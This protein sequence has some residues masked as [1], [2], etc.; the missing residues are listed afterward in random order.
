MTAFRLMMSAAL[1]ASLTS[2]PAFAQS[3]PDGSAWRA[4]AEQLEGGVAVDM[5]LRDGQHF[6]ATFIA[7]RPD[8]VLV[9]RK[10]RVPVSVEQIN[11][12]SIA[13]LSRAQRSNLS[14]GKIAAI[15]LGSA[16]AAV[17]VLWLIALATLD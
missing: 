16:G 9:Q 7:A 13:S 2:V 8:A 3:V 11:Y 6:K 17:G 5:R 1:I 12:E 4:L 10:T 15:A 14:A